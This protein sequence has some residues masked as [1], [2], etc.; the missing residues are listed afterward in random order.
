[1]ESH[2]MIPQ[3]GTML[4]LVQPITLQ[5]R[6]GSRKLAPA[7]SLQQLKR[8]S[9]LVPEYPVAFPEGTKLLTGSSYTN[10]TTGFTVVRYPGD[11]SLTGETLSLSSNT[12]QEVL[13]SAVLDRKYPYPQTLKGTYSSVQWGTP[14]EGK[15]FIKALATKCSYLRLYLV[16]SLLEAGEQIAMTMWQPRIEALALVP[17]TAP[18]SCYSRQV[19]TQDKTDPGS[20]SILVDVWLAGIYQNNCFRGNAANLLVGIYSVAEEMNHPH[21]GQ[22]RYGRPGE[23]PI[24]TAPLRLKLQVSAEALQ[25]CAATALVAGTSAECLPRNLIEYEVQYDDFTGSL[26][27]SFQVYKGSEVIMMTPMEATKLPCLAQDPRTI[28]WLQ[29][30]AGTPQGA[31]TPQDAQQNAED[32]LRYL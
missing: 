31:L 10:Q 4:T 32:H 13:H 21:P 30:H 12:I 19:P 16:G 28:M 24:C 20:L 7:K 8:G 1:M 11:L 14:Q 29:N 5:V 18:H 15:T 17:D 27:H 22:N 23:I 2:S 6:T 25:S 3:I 26:Q 9:A